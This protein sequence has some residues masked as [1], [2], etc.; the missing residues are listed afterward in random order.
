MDPTLVLGSISAVEATASRFDPTATPP[1][2]RHR[3]PTRRA[4]RRATATTL[5]RV[6]HRLEL[7]L[8]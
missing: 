7:G 1:R 6:A 5:H 8:T 2:A 4:L 3:R